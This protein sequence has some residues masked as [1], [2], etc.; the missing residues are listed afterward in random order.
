MAPDSENWQRC[1]NAFMRHLWDKS[2]SASTIYEYRRILTLF[3]SSGKHPS[4][5]TKADVEE[6]IHRETSGQRSRGK[7]PATATVNQRLMILRSWFAW[8]TEYTIEN[9][10]QVE[11]LLSTVPPTTGLRAGQ[12]ARSGKAMSEEE[13]SKF[14]SV[15]PKHTVK[16][17]RDTCIYL[18]FA[19]TAR[20]RSELANL[21]YGDIF[22]AILID[23]NGTRR[24]GYCFKFRGKGTSQT[25]DLQECPSLVVQALTRYLE[26]SNR[27]QTIKPEDPLF[28]STPLNKGLQFDQ[29]RP[30]SDET[31]AHSFK[32]YCRLAGLSTKYSLHSLRHSSALLR[33]SYGEDILSLQKTLRHRS[34]QTTTLYLNHLSSPVDKGGRA[35][36]RVFA[37][38]S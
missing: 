31:I 15:I 7:A 25:E 20:R 2:H 11:R 38:F 21:V 13:L 37:Q 6:F 14:F 12:A 4:L 28:V 18:F 34:L 8:A 33:Y 19:I 1:F 22:K 10:G 26:M 30:L 32:R 24:E 5:Y 3:F 17:A 36:E 27:L 9:N 35:L 23:A 16:G 29:S